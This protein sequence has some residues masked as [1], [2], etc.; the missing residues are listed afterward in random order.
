MKNRSVYSGLGVIIFALSAAFSFGEAIKVSGVDALFAEGEKLANKELIFEGMVISVCQSGGKKAFLRDATETAK[1]TL[2]VERGKSPAFDQEL[3][4]DTLQVKGVLR[5]NRIT[6]ESV[7]QM[8]AQANAIL[9]QERAKGHQSKE[10]CEHDCPE[11]I[12]AERMLELA[13]SYRALLAKS[14]KGYLSSFWV[15]SLHWEKVN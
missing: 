10:S 11:S 2:R 9:E 7:D 13:K 14:K 1:R 6:A 15:E 8:E 4:G 12:T 3:L 5:E